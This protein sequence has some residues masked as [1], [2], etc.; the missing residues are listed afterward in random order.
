MT[1]ES[2]NKF[3]KVC[4]EIANRQRYGERQMFVNKFCDYVIETSTFPNEFD[5][6]RG[7]KLTNSNTPQSVDRWA[8]Q[9][10]ARLRS[11][12]VNKCAS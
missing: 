11:V 3:F 10:A 4:N 9:M 7:L 2:K 1:H 8:F 6:A 5:L 12:F